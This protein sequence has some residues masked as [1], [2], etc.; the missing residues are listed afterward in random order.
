MAGSSL[1]HATMSL[2]QQQLAV[3]LPDSLSQ[4]CRLLATGHV[5]KSYSCTLEQGVMPTHALDDALRQSLFFVH[6]PCL[7]L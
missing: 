2:F 7:E 3:L 1:A 6:N 4:C 5:V